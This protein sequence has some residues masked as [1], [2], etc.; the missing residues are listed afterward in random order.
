MSN[1]GTAAGW[2]LVVAGSLMAGA[3]VAAGLRLP[4]CIVAAVTAFGG[5]SCWLP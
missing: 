3:L 5:G 1:V 2:G 4:P